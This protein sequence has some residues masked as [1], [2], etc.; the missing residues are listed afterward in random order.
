[1]YLTFKP[2]F[3]FL[4]LVIWNIT[5]EHFSVEVTGSRK[6]EVP[7]SGLQMVRYRSMATTVSK[8]ILAIPK[9]MLRAA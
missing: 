7:M 1:M 5:W 2:V 9:K 3:F 4:A 8:P 6:Q